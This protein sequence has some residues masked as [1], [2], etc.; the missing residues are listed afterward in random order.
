M[1]YKLSDI[2]QAQEKLANIDRNKLSMDLISDLEKISDII[3]EFNLINNGKVK[4]DIDIIKN[5]LDEINNIID[6]LHQ[7]TNEFENNLN[8]ERKTSHQSLLKEIN[9]KPYTWDWPTDGDYLNHRNS[10]PTAP[11]IIEKAVSLIGKYIDW[12]F[13]VHQVFYLTCSSL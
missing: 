1:N 3:T 7:L 13:P 10:W 8:L 9:N 2:L 5:K 4:R 12:R 6:E 11:F